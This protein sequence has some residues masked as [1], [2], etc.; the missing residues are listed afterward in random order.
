MFE[1]FSKHTQIIDYKDEEQRCF[2]GCFYVFEKNKKLTKIYLK[3]PYIYDEI[4]MLINIHEII[5]AI[6]LYK[7]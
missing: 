6:E 5:H 1:Y 4:T 7:K 2:I 3:L